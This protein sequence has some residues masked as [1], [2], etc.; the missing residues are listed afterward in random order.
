MIKGISYNK[1]YEVEIDGKTYT[2][3]FFIL[4]WRDMFQFL[5]THKV[6]SISKE[7]KENIEKQI[8]LF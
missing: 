4:E 8:A 7:E 6:V 5:K 2:G 3:R 1:D